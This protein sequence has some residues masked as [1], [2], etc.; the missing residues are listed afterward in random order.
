MAMAE[1]PFVDRDMVFLSLP[2]DVLAGAFRP[3]SGE[4]WECEPIDPVWVR[5]AVAAEDY[6]E[7]NW[8]AVNH[9]TRFDRGFDDVTYH[10]RRIAY[11]VAH[12]DPA[13]LELEVEG[14][15]LPGYPRRINL[16]D[17]NHRLGAAIIRKDGAM[18]VAVD[19]EH[20]EFVLGEFPEAVVLDGAACDNVPRPGPGA[21]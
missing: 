15:H 11:L 10:V 4:T 16:F 20:L 5:D 7:E 2:V 21:P 3:F 13:P 18:T 9:R 8:Q 6:E 12:P 17:G 19:A 14:G 1:H